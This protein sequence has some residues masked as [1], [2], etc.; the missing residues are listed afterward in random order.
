MRC[1][2]RT[3]SSS[4]ADLYSWMARPLLCWTRGVFYKVLAYIL[5]RC[6]LRKRLSQLAVSVDVHTTAART[7]LASG[8]ARAKLYMI[9]E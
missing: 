5:V 7:A 3:D 6:T 9:S 2:I 4:A 1:G 8:R